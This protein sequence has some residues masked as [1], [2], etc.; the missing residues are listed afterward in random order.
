MTD[1]QIKPAIQR[2]IFGTM[3]ITQ[4]IYRATVIAGF[5]LTPVIAAS[6]SGSDTT[7]G[8]PNTAGLIGQAVFAYPVGLIMDR[9]GR[10]WGLSAGYFIGVLGG[11][12]SAVS[13]INGSFIGFL[14]GAMMLGMMRGA[15]EQGRYVAAEVFPESQRPRIIGLI[16]FCGTAGAIIGPLL[17]EPATR[18]SQRMGLPAYTGPFLLAAGLML[19]VTI[20]IIL[21][22]RPD[23]LSLNRQVVPATVNSMADPKVKTPLHD[24]FNTP[25]I[26]LGVAAMVIGQLVMVLFMVV[27]PLHMDHHHHATKAISWV[28]M[29]HTLGMFGLSGLT[30][31]LVERI[32]RVATIVI[33]GLILL[34]SCILAPLSVALPILALALFL[35]G[36]GW[37][38]CFVAG[39]TLVAE[40]ATLANRGRAQGASEVA[41]ALASGLGSFLVGTVFAVGGIILLSVL[42]ALISAT[43]LLYTGYSARQ[44]R[45]ATLGA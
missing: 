43:L 34:L 41:V 8:Y 11:L 29:A 9:L 39:S 18:W 10:R 4:A 21:F 40:S 42:C 17:V 32:G 3:F 37:N 30:G 38:F 26:R 13:I 24:I 27:T 2:R 31:I 33:G 45:T 15:S 16:V 5:T 23:P 12:I 22:L 20:L 36:L 6:L 25:R 19:L 7:V 35:L 1:F 14:L 44:A 28:I